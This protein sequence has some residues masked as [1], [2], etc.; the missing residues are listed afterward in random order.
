MKKRIAALVVIFS[1]LLVLFATS[2]PGAGSTQA[3]RTCLRINRGRL[4]IQIGYCP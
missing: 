1:T 4:N 3:A 2:L